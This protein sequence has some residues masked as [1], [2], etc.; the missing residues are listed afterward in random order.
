[1]GDDGGMSVSLFTTPRLAVRPKTV[2]DAVPLHHVYGDAEVMR[3]LGGA[4]GTLARTEEFVSAHIKHQEVHG[5]SMWTL[6]ERPTGDVIGDVGFVVYEWGVEIGWHLRR[7]SWH[8]GYA[9]EAGRACLD[10][11]FS[12]VGFRRVSAF[13]EAANVASLRV[14]ERLGMRFVRQGADGVPPWNEYVTTPTEA[15]R[16]E[17]EALA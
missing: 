11:G 2:A 9:T 7:A 4:F 17:S 14:I 12:D 15:S 6:V 1:M 8:R 13:T 3:Y 16:R 5:F 10:Y